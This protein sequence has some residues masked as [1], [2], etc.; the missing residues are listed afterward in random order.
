MTATPLSYGPLTGGSPYSRAEE[1][2]NVEAMKADYY[3]HCKETS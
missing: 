2:A 3:A 1:L